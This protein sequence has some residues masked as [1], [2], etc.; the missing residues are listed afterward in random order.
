MLAAHNL[1]AEHS[2]SPCTVQYT[3]TVCPQLTPLNKKKKKKSIE[4]NYSA[5]HWL[6]SYII[7]AMLA[8]L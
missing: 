1:T 5:E 3:H 7:S 8:D 2:Y 4:Y 6:M